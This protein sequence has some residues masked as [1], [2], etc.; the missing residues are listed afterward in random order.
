MLVAI[1]PAGSAA[2]AGEPVGDDTYPHVYGPINRTAVVDV[3]PLD[4]RGA[5]RRAWSLLEGRP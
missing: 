4:R 3:S 5:R 2:E 1:D